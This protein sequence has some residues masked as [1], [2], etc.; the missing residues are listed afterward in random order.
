MFRKTTVKGSLNALNG[1]NPLGNKN[2]IYL[3]IILIALGVGG[4]FVVKKYNTKKD[5]KE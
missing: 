3:V 5:T 4:Y 2:W 1:S